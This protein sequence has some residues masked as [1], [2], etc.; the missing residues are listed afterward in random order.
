MADSNSL[1][2]RMDAEFAAFQ[3]KT[4]QFQVAAKAEYEAR[5]ARFHDMFVPAAKRLAENYYGQF[6]AAARPIKTPAPAA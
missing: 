4:E 2:E 5:E 3:Q 6:I 1:T